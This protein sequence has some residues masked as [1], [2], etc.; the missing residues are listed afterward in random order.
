MESV[1]LPSEELLV[2]VFQSSFAQRLPPPTAGGWWCILER[3][4][5]G[6]SDRPECEPQLCHLSLSGPQFPIS[7]MM[8]LDFSS[9]TRSA[10]EE[11][12]CQT[13][14]EPL[15]VTPLPLWCLQPQ[16]RKPHTLALSPP[17]LIPRAPRDVAWLPHTTQVSPHLPGERPAVLCLPQH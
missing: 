6:V 2:K 17:Q 10:L 4:A 15:A 7:Q 9:F 11:S 5:D 8:L 12:G 3:R 14:R 13:R 1:L 16:G